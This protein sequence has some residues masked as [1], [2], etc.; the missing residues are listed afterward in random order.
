M[1]KILIV[2]DDT[3]HRIMLKVN[4]LDAGYDVIEADDGDQVLPVLAEQEIDLILMDLKMQRM[5][6]LETI[7]LLREKGRVEPVVVITAFSSV[8]SAVEAMKYGAMDYVTKP[9]D[10]EALK[11][12]VAKAIDFEVLREE[13]KELKNDWVN[14]LILAILSVAVRPCRG[15]L[16]HCL[17]WHHPM[18]PCL[19]TENRAQARNSLPLPCI[20]TAVAKRNLL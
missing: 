14:S 13:N 16:K 1:K 9:V 18:P 8:E 12:T 11:H 17:L 5:D 6:G 10:I 4:L 7:H 3:V 19:S 2:D 15:F 20:T